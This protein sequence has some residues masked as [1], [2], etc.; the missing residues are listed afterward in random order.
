MLMHIES[1]QIISV[2]CLSLHNNAMPHPREVT[3][4]RNPYPFWLKQFGSRLCFAYC[5]QNLQLRRQGSGKMP[6]Q[7]KTLSSSA[8][9]SAQ[10]LSI[11]FSC[12]F[13]AAK[14]MVGTLKAT[15]RAFTFAYYTMAFAN[16]ATTETT[17]TTASTATAASTATTSSSATT[18]NKW[19]CLVAV[20]ISKHKWAMEAVALRYRSSKLKGCAWKKL[21]TKAPRG[22]TM[23]GARWGWREVAPSW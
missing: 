7:G 10:W 19:Q 21:D 12:S 16:T 22:L 23:R 6:R 13:V 8:A 3:I 14:F 17:A 11:A 20:M 9:W 18:E 4:S 15:F 1:I 5:I 2:Y